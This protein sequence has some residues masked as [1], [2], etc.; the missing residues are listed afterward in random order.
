MSRIKSE[1]L[2]K[3]DMM[4]T[5]GCAFCTRSLISI[6]RISLPQRRLLVNMQGRT[7]LRRLAPIAIIAYISIGG[8]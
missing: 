1:V 7:S 3:Y 8:S 6:S 5:E 4:V 2:M